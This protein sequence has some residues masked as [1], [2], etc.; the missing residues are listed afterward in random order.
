MKRELGSKE[1]SVVYER[2]SMVAAQAILQCYEQ[3]TMEHSNS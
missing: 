3:R 1:R 2:P